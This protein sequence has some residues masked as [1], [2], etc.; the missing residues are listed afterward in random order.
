ML[1]MNCHVERLPRA[2]REGDY[3]RFLTLH[4]DHDSAYQR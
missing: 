2:F 1:S 4:P 3:L